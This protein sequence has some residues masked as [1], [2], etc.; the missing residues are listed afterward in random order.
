MLEYDRRE[1]AF[2]AAASHLKRCVANIVNKIIFI[3]HN[4]I[5]TYEM[6][7]SGNGDS[8]SCWSR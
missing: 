4:Y 7:E 8:E 1:A 2:E 5:N 3:F 6:A